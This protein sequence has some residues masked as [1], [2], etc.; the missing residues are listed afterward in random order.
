MVYYSD[1]NI[2]NKGDF[3]YI[4]EDKELMIEWDWEEN[5]KLEIFPDKIK[6]KSHKKVW[7]VCKN[8]HKYQQT[9]NKRVSREYSCPYCSGHKA[10][11]GFNDLNSNYPE[12]AAEWHPEKNGELTPSQFTCGSGKRVWWLCPNGHEYQATIHDRVGSKTKCPECNKRRTSSFAEQAILFYVKKLYPNSIGKYRGVFENTMELDIFIPE[13]RVGI[14]F[15]GAYWHN[16]E[17]VH[18]R[19]I[20]KYDICKKNNITLFRIKE[21]TG[22]EWKDVADGIYYIEKSKDTYKLEKTI[23]D[24]MDSIDRESNA[25]TRKN[26]LQF[27]SS[28]KVDLE[29]DRQ[30]ILKYLSVVANSLAEKRPDLIEEWNYEKNGLL[31]PEMFHEHSN[32]SVWWKCKKCEYEWKTQINYRTR[33]SKSQCPKCALKDRGK[34]F[35]YNKVKEQ[36]SL[37]ENNPELAA[38][39][40][41][42]NNITPCDVTEKHNKKVWWKCKTCGFEWESSPNNRSKGV[43]C[44]YCSGRIPKQGINDLQTVNPRLASEWNFEKNGNSKPNEYLP[45]SGKKVWWRCSICGNEWEA[46][47]RNRSNGSGCPRCK[48]TNF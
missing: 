27:H 28:I 29:K 37:A 10:L 40:S 34:N 12:I 35:T 20:R 4:I 44:P 1:S 32:E 23:Q 17:E 30:E 18:Q 6:S 45:K 48:K 8:G 13:I 46:I 39:W 21:S 15:D 31:K 41:D 5:N 14:E 24:I 9:P 33:K 2:T 42:K 43:G 16:S 11:S 47:I 7:W 36:G 3:V 38:E 25:W 19:E 22:T 26:P